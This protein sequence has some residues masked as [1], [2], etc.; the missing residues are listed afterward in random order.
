M[1]GIVVA[2]IRTWLWEPTPRIQMLPAYLLFAIGMSVVMGQFASLS[3]QRIADARLEAVERDY[4]TCV[5]R[6]ETRSTLRGVFIG[7][8]DLFPESDAAEAI[9]D[10]I[11]SEYPALD[12]DVECTTILTGDP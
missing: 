10:L 7:I 12:L 2:R 4:G 8:V 5:N 6:V 3:E 1:A 9:R 11:E